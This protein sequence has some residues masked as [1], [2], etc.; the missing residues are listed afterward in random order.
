M[1]LRL[2]YIFIYLR[3]FNDVGNIFYIVYIRYKELNLRIFDI[4]N[5]KNDVNYIIF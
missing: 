4:L 3:L 5:K 1:I 2:L